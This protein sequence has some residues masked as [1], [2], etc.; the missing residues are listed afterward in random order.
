MGLLTSK[1]DLSPPPHFWGTELTSQMRSGLS[2][3]KGAGRAWQ[4]LGI[5]TS[6]SVLT[7]RG[8][9]PGIMTLHDHEGAGPGRCRGLRGQKRWLP[10]PI[11]RLI[12]GCHS[13]SLS[14]GSHL[15]GS[16]GQEATFRGSK[17]L[18]R[19]KCCLIL[20]ADGTAGGNHGKAP[21]RVFLTLRSCY[22]PGQ[23]SEGPHTWDCIG[24][25][26]G[27]AV[28]IP[29]PETTDKLPGDLAGS[30]RGQVR[31]E[32][33]C[34]PGVPAGSDQPYCVCCTVWPPRRRWEKEVKK[35][36]V[37]KNILEIIEREI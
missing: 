25:G 4:S 36:G 24:A 3:G 17:T 19:E 34:V 27:T 5:N 29:G 10:D 37:W 7:V 22:F 12:S 11:L 31:P 2:L 28:L 1:A 30:D 15:T 9:G 16:G 33:F 14:L 8:W 13:P 20:T 35:L 18:S 26:Q 32:A 23:P 6:V 21:R